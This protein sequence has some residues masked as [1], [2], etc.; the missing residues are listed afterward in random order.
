[1]ALRISSLEIEGFKSFK[2][3]A[4]LTFPENGLVLISGKWKGTSVSSGSGKSSVLEAIAFCFDI[5]DVPATELKN[6]DSKKMFVKLTLVD[7]HNTYE[8][9]RDPKLSLVI[10]GAPYESLATGAKDKLKE[11]LKASPEIIRAITYR[12]QREKGKF[13][14]STDSELKEFLTQPLGLNEIELAADSLVKDINLTS[15]TIDGLKREINAYELSAP[16]EVSD[17]EIEAAKAE[18]ELSVQSYNSIVNPEAE[19]QISDEIQYIKSKIAEAEMLKTKSISTQAQNTSLK[20]SI[21]S[22]QQEIQSLESAVCPT[23][24]RSWQDK[25][26]ASLLSQKKEQYN[27]LYDK[28]A[29]NISFIKNSQLIIDNI[30]N[31]V[32]MN[33]EAMHKLGSLKSPIALAS[34][35]VSLAKNKL[36]QLTERKSSV[37]K[38]LARLEASKK[39]LLDQEKKLSILNHAS[40]ILGRSGFLGSIFDEI[41]QDIESRSNEMIK[42]L[43]NIDQFAIMVSSTKITKTKGTAKKEITV[44]VTKNGKEVS[45]KSLSGG[46]QCGLELCSD[47]AS[48]E[49]IRSR[50]GVPLGWVCLDEAMD[51]LGVDEKQA[52]IAMIKERV[53][54]LVLIIDHATEI[55]EGFDKII[56]IEFDGKESFIAE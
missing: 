51:G 18:Y 34:Q 46:Q 30:P 12:P 42:C 7:D 9:I 48:A 10:N 37:N 4:V 40:N 56:E 33:N 36:A 29:T 28:L 44:N 16:A 25:S 45:I 5:C 55:K 49:A 21:L 19:K 1:M 13:I 2:K 52:A 8:I 31:L 54:G 32:Q 14:T 53:N 38:A 17:A 20:E 11:I 3:K 27:Q 22:L 43:P 26:T 15:M 6:W 41:L 24:E 47:L 50:S 39:T 35:N 23:C